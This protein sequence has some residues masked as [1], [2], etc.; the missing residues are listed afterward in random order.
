[1]NTLLLQS[2]NGEPNIATTESN[3]YNGDQDE[4]IVIQDGDDS[5]WVEFSLES[6]DTQEDETNGLG[7]FNAEIV[8]D[9]V[10]NFLQ[11]IKFIIKQ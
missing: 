3:N 2:S 7:I 11:K 6:F 5:F 4:E 1:M 10:Q 9:M 8:M